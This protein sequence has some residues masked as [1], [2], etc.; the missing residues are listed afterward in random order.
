MKW[1]YTRNTCG[2]SSVTVNAC[3]LKD[4]GVFTCVL[5]SVS[6]I[7][8]NIY[9]K[10]RNLPSTDVR[11]YSIVSRWLL[12]HPVRIV[13]INIKQ[14]HSIF[15]F[16]S[17]SQQLQVPFFYWDLVFFWKSSD[18]VFVKILEFFLPKYCDSFN[19]FSSIKG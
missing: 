19:F 2:Y 9:C 5:L 8:A 13:I 17:Y 18:P 4:A 16:H 1:I 15:Y 12:R 11:N 7:T 3:T 6:Y 14:T 10:S